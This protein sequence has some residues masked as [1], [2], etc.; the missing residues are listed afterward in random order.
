M[1]QV[2]YEGIWKIGVFRPIS[3]FYRKQYKIATVTIEYEEELVG[4]PSNGAICMTL[5][6]P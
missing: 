3:S 1:M 5:S 4:G 6:D 2:K